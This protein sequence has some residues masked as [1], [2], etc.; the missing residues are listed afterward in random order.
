VTQVRRLLA[1]ASPLRTWLALAALASALALLANV[2]LMAVA[3]TLISRA[4]VVTGFA[5]IALAVTAVRGLAV[6]RASLRYAERY[7]AHVAALRILARLR[8]RLYLALEP[9][10]PAGL[11]GRPGGDLL[12]RVVA[13]VEALDG[14]FV[15][16]LLPPVAAAGAG[17][18]ACLVAAW[19]D[20]RLGLVLLASL[21]LAGTALPLAARR[22]S[23]APAAGLA[24]A[25]GELHAVLAEQV[26]GL[27]DLLACG[28]EAEI[29]DRVAETTAR[30]ARERGRLASARGLSAGGG[31]LLPGLSG[32]AL[33]ALAIPLVRGGAVPGVLLAAVPLVGLAAFEGVQSLGEAFREVEVGRA[34]AARTFEL[35][36]APV[37]SP[38]PPRPRPLAGRPDVELRGVRFRYR[39]AGPPVLDDVSLRLPAGGRLGIAGP[40]GAGKTTVVNLLLRF[41]EAESGSVLLGGRDVRSCRAEEVRARFGV[42]PQ[43]IH[44]FNGTLRDNLLL[45]D[46]EAADDRILDACDQAA[47]GDLVR[48]LPDGLDTLVGEDGLALSGGERQRV[49]L[50][51]VFLRGAPVVV[52]DEATAN[53]DAATERRVLRAVDTFATGR[54]LLVISHRSAPL[55]LVDRVVVLPGRPRPA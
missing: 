24:S 41:W 23:R 22:L 47:L 48:S 50:A 40:S 49:A 5:D 6:A 26:G 10:A 17:V 4:A 44:L 19:L 29:G 52:L 15:R 45:A 12:A 35:L 20:P 27:P 21:M 39:P 51:R 2:A 1:L 54:S 30:M 13:D 18:G 46:G 53:L 28:R 14:F 55:E 32:L 3:P 34:A 42:A 7:A 8:V 33:L 43:R 31:A 36:D 11:L 25:R 16:G 38:D 37:P 9:L